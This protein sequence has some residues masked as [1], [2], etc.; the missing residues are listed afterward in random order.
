MLSS[1]V[2]SQ[3]EGNIEVG[4]LLLCKADKAKMDARTKHFE[5]VADNR[6]SPWTIIS[7]AKMTLVCHCSIQ[8]E[9]HGCLHLVRT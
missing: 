1:D 5:Q 9:A 2:G 4:G 3:F 7:C 8:S 6:C